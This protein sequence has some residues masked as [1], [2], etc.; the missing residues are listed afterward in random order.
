[1]C[2][3]FNGDVGSH[4]LLL[5]LPVQRYA[6]TYLYKA[7][8]LL[9]IGHNNFAFNSIGTVCF[10]VDTSLKE[11]DATS[12]MPSSGDYH[13][14][15]L[16]KSIDMCNNSLFYAPLYQNNCPEGLNTLQTEILED[17]FILLIHSIDTFLFI[18]ALLLH[19]I[20]YISITAIVESRNLKKSFHAIDVLLNIFQS[21]FGV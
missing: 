3:S 21:L 14:L 5:L 17:I 19:T 8:D 13:D 11:S 12:G 15:H 16:L 1:M 18:F 7:V 4:S 9:I 10:L 2:A 20:C 6:A